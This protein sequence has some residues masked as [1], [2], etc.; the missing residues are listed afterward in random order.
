MGPALYTLTFTTN[1]SVPPDPPEPSTSQK[2]GE[3]SGNSGQVQLFAAVGQYKK[4]KVKFRGYNSTG[5]GP[6]TGSYLYTVDLRYRTISVNGARLS[7]NILQP[8]AVEW[9][10]FVANTAGYYIIE[11]WAGT[12]FDNYMYL[13]GPNNST[14]LVEEDDDDGNERAA[15]IIRYLS[16][17]TYYVKIRAYYAS[18]TGTYKI[19][20]K[21]NVAS[22]NMRYSPNPAYPSYS[23]CFGGKTPQWLYDTYLQ[24]MT[25]VGVSISSFKWDF[26]DSNG[27]YSSTQ[28][29]TAT[30]FANWFNRCGSGSSYIAPYSRVCA[31]LCVYLGGRSSGSV[32]MTFYGTDNNGNAISVS[33]REYLNSSNSASSTIPIEESMRFSLPQAG[34]QSK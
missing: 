31:N 15:K 23:S 17:G 30:D 11:T 4:I 18:G 16:L 26:Y 20:V 28:Y 14:T 8:G 34:P 33:E 6:T 24:E 19:G 29:N 9:Y 1:G 2:T 25:G 21:T 10:R 3:I 12:L 7:G 27:N 22:L 13:Y 5:Y 32:V